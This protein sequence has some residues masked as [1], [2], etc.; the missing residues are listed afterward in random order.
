MSFAEKL[1]GLRK[2]KGISQEQ[3]AEL[4]DVSRQSISKWESGQNYP[5]VDKLIKLSDLFKITLDELLKD[6]VNSSKAEKSE[7]HNYL[8][9]EEADDGEYEEEEDEFGVN[10]ILGCS[11]IGTVIAMMTNNFMWGAVGGLLGLGL[12]YLFKGI[13]DMMIKEG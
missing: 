9:D 1:Q 5:E 6:K 11:I 8:K 12:P 4:L 10:F 2:S 7:N 13:K 3:L